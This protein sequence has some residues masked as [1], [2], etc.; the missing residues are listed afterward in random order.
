MIRIQYRFNCQIKS[1]TACPRSR[2]YSNLPVSFHSVYFKLTRKYIQNE[3]APYDT[4]PGIPIK[5]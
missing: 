5:A 3:K 2:V 4:T 1:N